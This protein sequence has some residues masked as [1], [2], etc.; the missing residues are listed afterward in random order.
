MSLDNL[1]SWHRQGGNQATPPQTAYGRQVV[2]IRQVG[3]IQQPDHGY[4]LS[5]SMHFIQNL[6]F[7]NKH[8]FLL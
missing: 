7:Y 5:F 3:G 4:F 8:G 2:G 6:I 1:T